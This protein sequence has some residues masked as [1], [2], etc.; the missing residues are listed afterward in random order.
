MTLK[1]LI[2]EI[3]LKVEF[4]DM[5]AIECIEYITERYS[6][7]KRFH[8]KTLKCDADVYWKNAR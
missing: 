1:R 3:L 7:R 6:S 2:I 8:L 4:V 5:S